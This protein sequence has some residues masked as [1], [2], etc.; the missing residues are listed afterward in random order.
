MDGIHDLG[1]RQGFGAVQPEEN[2]PTFHDRWEA[3]VFSIMRASGA[4]GVVKNTDQFR[5]AIERIDP[6]CYLTH[7]YYGR[8]LGGLE[9]LLCEAGIVTREEL[10]KRAGTDEEVAARPSA[11]PQ[12]IDYAGQPSAQRTISAVPRFRAGDRVICRSTPFSGH[13][14]LPAYARGKPGVI[15]AARGGWVL[16]DTNAHGKGECPEHL[17]TVRFDGQTLWGAEA[18]PGSSVCIDLFESYLEVK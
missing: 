1:G 8:W 16:P 9:T 17:Y 15:H 5:H 18:E 2:E 14:R 7:G 13:T 11:T 12:T 4:A 3:A 6:V 10:S